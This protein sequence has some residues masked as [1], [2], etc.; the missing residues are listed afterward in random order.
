MD[1]TTLDLDN[2]AL[3]GLHSVSNAKNKNNNNNKYNQDN[4]D[5]KIEIG[6]LN[7]GNGELGTVRARNINAIDG[8]SER[9]NLLVSTFDITSRSL[10]DN[11]SRKLRGNRASF[12]V[13]DSHRRA[14]VHNVGQ[15]TASAH[16]LVSAL[17]VLVAV[18]VGVSTL[19]STSEAILLRFTS[20]LESLGEQ[21][22]LSELEA[23]TT[24][25][26]AIRRGRGVNLSV[27]TLCSNQSV[28]VEA[29][30]VVEV[31]GLL[32][33][34]LGESLSFSFVKDGPTTTVVGSLKSPG[35]RS[36]NITRRTSDDGVGGDELSSVVVVGH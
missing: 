27:G 33:A 6:L 8:I 3:G 10:K 36:S 21:A 30:V 18:L 17:V 4:S 9:G 5:S 19:N 34:I 13:I 25:I 28:L 2:L 32:S 15:L 14:V 26:R 1:L 20:S 29:S 35:T 24:T 16:G 7:E 11:T 23:V 12:D 22:Q 31:V